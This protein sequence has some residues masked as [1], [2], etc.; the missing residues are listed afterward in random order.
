MLTGQAYQLAI[1]RD[2]LYREWLAPNKS[3]VGAPLNKRW[4]LISLE[5]GMHT[6]GIFQDGHLLDIITDIMVC[7]IIVHQGQTSF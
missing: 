7:G 5:Y 4:V 3:A 6:Q 2:D 1:L